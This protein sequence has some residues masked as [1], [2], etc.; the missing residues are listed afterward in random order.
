MSSILGAVGFENSPAYVAAKHGILGLTQNA[1]L[2]YSK[3]GVRVNSVGP[4]FIRTPLIS[5]LESD[6][7]TFNLLV[8][9]HPI[10]R[11]GEPEEV[12]E[13]VVW[14]RQG[15]IRHRRLLPGGW[16]LSGAL[17]SFQN[18]KEELPKSGQ[19]FFCR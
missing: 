18:T 17:T 8:S 4:A 6:Q 13:L 16:R 2:E 19:L 15:F 7:Q 11:L 3:L 5:A 10:G 9:L 1:A 14:L 12:A